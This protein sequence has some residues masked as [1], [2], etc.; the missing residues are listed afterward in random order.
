MLGIV[1]VVAVGAK[2]YHA[3]WSA[4]NLLLYRRTAAKGALVEVP[5]NTDISTVSP[6]RCLAIGY[7]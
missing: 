5:D 3:A 7:L 4:P 6:L 1:A 2:G